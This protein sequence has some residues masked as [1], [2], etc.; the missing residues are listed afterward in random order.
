MVEDP[1]AHIVAGAG[2]TVTVGKGFTVTV[3]EAAVEVHPLLSVTVTEYEVVLAG[4]TDIE[5]VVAP[6]DQL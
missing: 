5:E 1:P 3:A 6:V 4:V 2:V